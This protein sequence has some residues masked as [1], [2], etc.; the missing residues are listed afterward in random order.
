MGEHLFG[1]LSAIAAATL[2]SLVAGLATGLG[3]LAVFL[4]RE[5]T[6]R[7]RDVLLGFAAGIMLAATF[8]SL[9]LPGIAASELAGN[10]PFAAVLTVSV[11]FATGALTLAAVH[12]VL[13]HQHIPGPREGARSVELARIWLFVI[14]IALHNVPEGL[15]VGVAFAGGDVAR[16]VPLMV[17]IA[18]QNVPEGLAVATALASV[19]YARAT[20]FWV[21]VASGLVE[22]VAGLAGAAA[23]TV[24]APLLAPALGFAAGAMLF[25][26]SGE[27]IPE[28]HRH[29]SAKLAT[30]ALIAGFVL[31]MLLDAALPRA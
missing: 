7:L 25:V 31:M 9:L 4:V 11:G 17:G 19:G 15:A 24:F 30:F 3:A 14:A 8:F 23:V 22:P 26:I 18:M 2:A 28:T 16:G 29:E 21:A 10:A 27:I 12:R 20:A 6:Q 1:D 5:L 13:P